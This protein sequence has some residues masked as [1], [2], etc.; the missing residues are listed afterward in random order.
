M[1]GELF[2]LN[3]DDDDDD[4]LDINLMK[5]IIAQQCVIDDADF[6]DVDNYN[7]FEGY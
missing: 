3:Y 2:D 6:D 5:E 1:S 4:V 7:I